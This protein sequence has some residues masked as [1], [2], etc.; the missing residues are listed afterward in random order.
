MGGAGLVAFIYDD[1]SLAKR[2]FL[3]NPG[4]HLAQL[5]LA[6]LAALKGD[7]TI[8]HAHLQAISERN[9]AHQRPPEMETTR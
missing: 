3:R 6:H 9:R 2:A 5:G 7:T 1:F 8:A 4:D